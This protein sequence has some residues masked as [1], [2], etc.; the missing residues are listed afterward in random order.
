MTDLPARHDL[1]IRQGE[2]FQFWFA[3][4]LPDGST[5]NLPN[6]G[7]GY[8]IGRMQVRDKPASE[9]GVVLLE[10]T[11]ENGGVWLDYQ[12]DA[13][14]VPWSGY[15]YASANATA[16]LVPWGEAVWDFEI[17]NGSNVR[18]V[19]YGSATLEPEITV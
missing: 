3:V 7:E 8:T 9:G 5:A 1:I 6:I 10:L 14:G 15:L 16:A 19:L 12:I 2:D 17:S 18:K 4:D 13:D 11:D